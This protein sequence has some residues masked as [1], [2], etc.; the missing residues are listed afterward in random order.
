MKTTVLESIV[1]KI[2]SLIACIFIE[3]DTPTQIFFCD[4]C[5]II[6]NSFFI[7]HLLL[8]ILFRNL[9]VMIEFFGSLWV[10]N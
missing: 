2:A 8:I 10:Q 3:K 7:E 5:E 4:Y 9:Y 6:E 1:D